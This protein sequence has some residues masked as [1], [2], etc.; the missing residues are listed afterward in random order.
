M[1]RERL[2]DTRND[3]DHNKLTPE[4]RLIAQKFPLNTADPMVMI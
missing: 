3:D 4:E 2:D 1:K